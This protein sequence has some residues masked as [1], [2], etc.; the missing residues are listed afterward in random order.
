MPS[1]AALAQE[2][3]MKNSDYSDDD[4][5]GKNPAM[6]AGLPRFHQEPLN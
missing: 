3:M 6:E 1:Q 4:E 2:G 5:A